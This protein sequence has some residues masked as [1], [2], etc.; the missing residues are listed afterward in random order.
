M[1][2]FMPT[3]TVVAD[4]INQQGNRLTTFQ[5]RYWRGIH[6]ELM[7]HRKFSRCAGSSRARPSQAIID[8]VRSTPWGPPSWGANQPGM[9][10]DAE[11]SPEK[12]LIAKAT[13]VHAANNAAAQ[14]LLLLQEGAHKQIVNRLLE[15]FTFIDVIVSSTEYNN[16]WALREDA[17]ADPAIRLLAQEMHKAYDAS[18]PTLLLPGTWHLPFVKIDFELQEAVDFVES[19]DG[20]I[21]APGKS[22]L[23]VLFMVSAARC[24]RTSYR[25][26]DGTVAPIKD[27]V[28]LFRKLVSANLVHASPLEHQ[29]TPDIQ[30]KELKWASPD[31]H[32]NFTGWIQFRKTVPNE[33]V[34]G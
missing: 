5:L 11:L 27:D 16:W 21:H 33:Y 22:P 3:A 12:T 23:D 31:L 20:V 13:W 8:Q 6:S 4:S 2:H 28:I 15:P 34:P 30:N 14:A 1:I 7:T 9:Q 32:G 10:A 17:A 24:A 25:T 26:F 19:Q 29:A 18:T